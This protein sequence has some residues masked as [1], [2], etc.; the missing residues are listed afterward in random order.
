MSI[1]VLTLLCV[2]LRYNALYIK[3]KLFALYNNIFFIKVSKPKTGL[4][5]VFNN[6]NPV[7][8]KTGFNI[9]NLDCY[10]RCIF[11]PLTSNIKGK[12]HLF[13][14][15]LTLIYLYTPL[16]NAKKIE[17]NCSHLSLKLVY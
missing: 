15:M 2:Y 6:Q 12:L 13:S 17:P 16:K 4:K 14:L 8:Q 10:K 9:P 5:P 1:T 3:L 11:G 7:F